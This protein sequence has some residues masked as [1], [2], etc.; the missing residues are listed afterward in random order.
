MIWGI[1]DGASVTCPLPSLPRT[2]HNNQLKT[3][4]A[5]ESFVLGYLFDMKTRLALEKTKTWLN[6]QVADLG[7]LSLE[8]KYSKTKRSCNTWFVVC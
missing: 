8:W 7:K 2:G 3:L 1:A 4:C 5:A 6:T